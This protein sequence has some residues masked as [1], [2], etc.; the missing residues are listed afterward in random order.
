MS[1]VFILFALADGISHQYYQW[2]LIA[3]VTATLAIL[4]ATGISSLIGS[5]AR[6]S[7][8]PDRAAQGVTAVLLVSALAYGVVFEASALSGAGLPGLDEVTDP[9][10]AP[11]Q[12][13]VRPGEAAQAGQDLRGMGVENVSRVVFVGPE[14]NQSQRHYRLHSLSRVLIYA[15][16]L[17]RERVPPNEVNRVN[18][19]GPTFW[20]TNESLPPCEPVIFRHDGRIRVRPCRE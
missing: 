11:L 4:L 6:L 5:T 2:G 14:W 18:P 17:P 1:G 8:G 20:L 13:N 19:D 16:L 3:P 7:V 9:T 15:D 12:D 10:A